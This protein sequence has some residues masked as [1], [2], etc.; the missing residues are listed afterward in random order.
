MTGRDFDIYPRR[1]DVCNGSIIA[2]MPVK[3]ENNYLF[4][5]AAIKESIMYCTIQRLLDM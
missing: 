4:L 3:G 5:L 2:I 1:D